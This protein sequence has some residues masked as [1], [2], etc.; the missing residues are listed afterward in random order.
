M[1]SSGRRILFLAWRSLAHPQGGGSEV[2][3]DRFLRGLQERGNTVALLAGGPTPDDSP[4][5]VRSIGGRF[6]QYLRAPFVARAGGPWDVIVDVENGIP[7]FSPLWQR[8]PVVCF[9]NHV[10]LE[11]WPLYFPK[12][13]ALVGQTLEGRAMPRVYRHELYA[14]LSASTRDALIDLGVEA[15]RIRIVEVGVDPLPLV[16]VARA[17]EPTF[18]ALGRLVPHKRLET[19]LRVWARVQPITGGQFVIV[20]DGP[21][22][23]RLQAQAGSGVVFTG[24]VSSE[25]KAEW[26]HRAWLLVH[27]AM[28][29]G[30]GLIVMEAGLAGTPTLAFD[31]HGIRDAAVAGETAVLVDS[32]DAF[33]EEW[34][35]L[36]KDHAERERL[37]ANA[38]RRSD[39]YT[40]DRTNAVF[41]DVIDEAI[42]RR[43][44]R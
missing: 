30:W 18:V 37:G 4:Y 13:V 43:Q 12:P 44:T 14:V 32:E 25:E 3:T 38:K 40:W 39:E 8:A 26:L 24:F 9:V 6:S 41:A 29:E 7:Y 22:M 28:H 36:A 17:T 20:G 5:P 1:D 27:G 16:S 21:E 31:V 33:V 23:E 35:R 10:H 15:D 19:L 2:V 11:Q 34:I 42:N